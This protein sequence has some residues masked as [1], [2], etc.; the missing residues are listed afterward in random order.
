MIFLQK[1]DKKAAPLDD[2]ND[3]RNPAFI[4]RKGRFY[5]HDDRTADEPEQPKPFV[6]FIDLRLN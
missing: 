2:D 4:P 3:A 5:E 6:L 1:S